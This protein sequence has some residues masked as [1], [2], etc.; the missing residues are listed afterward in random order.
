MGDQRSTAEVIEVDYEGLIDDIQVGDQLAVG[1]GKVSLRITEKHGDKVIAEVTSGGL[2]RGR[3]GIHVPSDRLSMATPT[4]EDFEAI[5]DNP[6]VDLLSVGAFIGLVGAW[7]GWVHYVG[8][9]RTVF[10]A[11]SGAC[12]AASAE[13][14]SGYHRLAA[15]DAA[16]ASTGQQPG[17]DGRT[18]P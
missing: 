6:D 10:D 1:D 17:Q 14:Q 3:P 8:S 13:P 12:A 18:I 4:P 5:E 7:A 15:P 11:P 9:Q 16:A 2:V